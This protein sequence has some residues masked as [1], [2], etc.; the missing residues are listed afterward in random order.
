MAWLKDL[1]GVNKEKHEDIKGKHLL[2]QTREAERANLKLLG[3]GMALFNCE[4]RQ[5]RG[6]PMEPEE[7]PRVT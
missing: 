1:R 6:P 7:P 3:N 4:R 2:L 5:F